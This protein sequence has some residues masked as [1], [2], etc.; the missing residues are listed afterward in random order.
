MKFKPQK[1]TPPPARRPKCSSQSGILL[2]E[3]LVYISVV[4]I[5][6]GLATAFGFKAMENSKSLQRAAGDI[7]RTLEAGEKWRED[8]RAAAGQIK[9]TLDERDLVLEIPRGAG[10]VTY[11]V[12]GK[13]VWRRP[14]DEAHFALVV[15]NLK[16]STMH[17][18]E[19]RGIKSW[20]WEI[21]LA[22][23]SKMAKVR[24]LF[25]FLAVPPKETGQ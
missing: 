22:T 12:E 14:T 25:T 23:V 18:D 5:L 3:A 19:A 1:G 21:E 4:F 17:L 9:L 11:W 2:M 7:S 8:I 6:A 16:H 10:R 20:R 15:K 24:P 13:N